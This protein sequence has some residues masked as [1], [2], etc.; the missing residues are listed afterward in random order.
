[1]MWGRTD[2]WL[3]GP[4]NDVGGLTVYV[5]ELTDDVGRTDR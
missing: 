1:M 4:T 5:A 2:H 3:E